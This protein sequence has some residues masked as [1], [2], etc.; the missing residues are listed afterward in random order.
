ML[1]VFLRVHKLQPSESWQ[2]VLTYKNEKHLQDSVE[3]LSNCEDVVR[4]E[5]IPIPDRKDKSYND[6]I[7][8]YFKE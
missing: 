4:V 7:K 8:E 6:A 2:R 3:Q 5:V 1:D